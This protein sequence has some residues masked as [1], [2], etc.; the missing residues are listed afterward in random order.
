MRKPDV[1]FAV[2]VSRV[3]RV[4]GCQKKQDEE[5]RGL[6]GFHSFASCPDC[7]VIPYGW[8]MWGENGHCQGSAPTREQLTHWLRVKARSQWK[9][10]AGL[11]MGYRFR[12]GSTIYYRGGR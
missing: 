11:M 4:I 10:Q 8:E 5:N 3:S 7:Q 9:T 2:T 1:T 6:F 12:V